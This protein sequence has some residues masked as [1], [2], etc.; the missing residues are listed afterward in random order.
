MTSNLQYTV[1]FPRGRK[2]K[3]N[4]TTEVMR[5]YMEKILN[6]FKIL[7]TI[8]YSYL[9][10]YPNIGRQLLN[11]KKQINNKCNSTATFMFWISK[12]SCIFLTCCSWITQVPTFLYFSSGFLTHLQGNGPKH[13]LNTGKIKLQRKYFRTIAM[14]FIFLF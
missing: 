1:I 3:Q 6:I 5:F 4:T 2:Q 7:K 14:G 9:S 12:C 13:S 10:S 8:Y 11:T